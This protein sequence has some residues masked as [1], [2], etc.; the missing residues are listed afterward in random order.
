MENTHILIPGNGRLITVTITE[1]G[2]TVTLGGDSRVFTRYNAGAETVSNDNGESAELEH[3][4]AQAL[5]DKLLTYAP[6][7]IVLA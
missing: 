1:T 4:E 2:T 6:D 7:A 5:F 3:T